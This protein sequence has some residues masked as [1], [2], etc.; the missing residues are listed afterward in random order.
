MNPVLKVKDRAGIKHVFF[1][2][3][4]EEN[5]GILKDK[6]IYT[7]KIIPDG[8]PIK[9]EIMDIVDERTGKVIARQW[10]KEFQFIPKDSSYEFSYE[11][12]NK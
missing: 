10:L 5:A 1:P 9:F 2:L 4:V 6:T 3:K 7:F 8:E 12:K 11:F